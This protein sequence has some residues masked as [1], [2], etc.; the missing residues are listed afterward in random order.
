VFTKN[1]YKREY[2]TKLRKA[3]RE[4][5]LTEVRFWFDFEGTKVVIQD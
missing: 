2:K 5:E 1:S 4:K 3:I